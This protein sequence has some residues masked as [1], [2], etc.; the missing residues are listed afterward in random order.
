MPVKAEEGRRRKKL[1]N[2]DP[3]IGDIVL[4]EDSTK[5]KCFGKIIRLI[6]QNQVVVLSTLNIK[7]IERDLHKR[8]LILLFRKS[9]WEDDFPKNNSTT[10][11][12]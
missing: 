7:H 9:E 1:S 8:V 2:L 5:H 6:D 3:M 12:A 11:E 10:I 4:Y